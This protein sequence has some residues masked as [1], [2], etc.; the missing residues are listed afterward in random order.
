VF[1]SIGALLRR[2]KLASSRWLEACSFVM[3]VDGRSAMLDGEESSL[4]V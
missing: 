3:N 2:A 1:G 4:T